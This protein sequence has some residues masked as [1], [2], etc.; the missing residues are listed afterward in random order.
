MIWAE[1]N[2]LES[3]NGIESEIR[4]PEYEDNS[5]DEGPQLSTQTNRWT[6]SEEIIF[7]ELKLFWQFLFFTETSFWELERD[8]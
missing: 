8:R 2:D 7:E 4:Q 6:S 3:E 5:F 1:L